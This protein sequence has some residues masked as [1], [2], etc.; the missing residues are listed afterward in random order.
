M[1]YPPSVYVAGPMRG[2]PL[3]NFPAFDAASDKLRALDGKSFRPQS[4]TANWDSTRQ[5]RIWTRRNST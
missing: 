5:L 3:F 4:M 2:Y 1:S